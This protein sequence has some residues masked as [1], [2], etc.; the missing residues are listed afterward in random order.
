MRKTIVVPTDFSVQSL[1]VL[2]NILS[3]NEGGCQYDIVL[4]HGLYLT[5]SITDLMFMSKR[6]LAEQLSNP[7]FEEACGV[8]C[9][10]F[11]SQ[12]SSIRKDI[13]TGFTQSA[14]DNYL[15]ANRVE[16]VYVSTKK[17]FQFTDKRSFDILPFVYKSAV[18]V[19]EVA[20]ETEARLPEKGKVAEV[21]YNSVAAG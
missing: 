7:A 20:Y 6:R 17:S 2:K 8:I 16:D 4:L 14:F 5:D 12:I 3:E 19:H 13:F 15:E 9:S 21:F 11:D 1:N 18:R 10:K